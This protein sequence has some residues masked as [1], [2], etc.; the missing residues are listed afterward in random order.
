MINNKINDDININ[1]NVIQKF[2]NF[3]KIDMIST[4]NKNNN[5]NDNNI[6]P[7]D[8]QQQEYYIHTDFKQLYNDKYQIRKQLKYLPYVSLIVGIKYYYYRRD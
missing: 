2:D 7:N 6:L 1:N 5:Q 3:I 8:N 4:I